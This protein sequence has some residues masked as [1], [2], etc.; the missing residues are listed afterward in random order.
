MDLLDEIIVRLREIVAEDDVELK[1]IMLDSLLELLEISQ[2]MREEEEIETY[3]DSS[4]L[5][6][7]EETTD[8]IAAKKILKKI[9]GILM[10]VAAVKMIF[11]K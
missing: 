6:G 9:F 2:E 8:N 7:A 3:F 10:I 11:D 1:L 4:W 5:Y